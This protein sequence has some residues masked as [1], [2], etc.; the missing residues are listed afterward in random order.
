MA[1]VS[2]LVHKI[3]RVQRCQSQSSVSPLRPCAHDP[4]LAVRSKQV[5]NISKSQLWKTRPHVLCMGLSG[6]QTRMEM[7]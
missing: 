4:G 1:A 3:P 2:Q 6:V 5:G 7:F